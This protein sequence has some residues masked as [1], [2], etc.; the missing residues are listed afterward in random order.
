MVHIEIVTEKP[1]PKN[2]ILLEGFQGVGLVATLAAEYIA[3]KTNSKLIGYVSSDVFPP[4]AILSDG[5]LRHPTRIYSFK[6]HGQNFLIISSELPIPHGITDA[7]ARELVAFAK[8]NNVKEIVSLEGITTPKPPVQSNVYFAA[9]MD[10]LNKRLIKFAKQL[11]NGI[12][13]GISAQVLLQARAKKV[14]A[15]SIMAEAH[16]EFPDGIAAAEIIKKLN[17][18]YK[19]DIDVSDLIKES[20]KFEE[21]IWALV[22]KARQIRS[23]Q[24]EPKKTYIG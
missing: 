24:G 15:F 8:K 4:M 21:K 7:V 14:P 23:A 17:A 22:E 2:A 12:I 1:V 5:Q 11:K 9:N 16:A 13:V 6:E 19:L 3:N 10:K 20:K 18:L